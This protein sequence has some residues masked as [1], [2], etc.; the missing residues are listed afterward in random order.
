[1]FCIPNQKCI[2]IEKFD[3]VGKYKIKYL[4]EIIYTLNFGHHTPATS[5]S[6]IPYVLV[7]RVELFSLLV[8]LGFKN[9]AT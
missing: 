9:M 3:C 1:M 7:K 5:K 4:I 8:P 6:I 2:R